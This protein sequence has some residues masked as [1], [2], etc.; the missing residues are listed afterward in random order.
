[1]VVHSCRTSQ[2]WLLRALISLNVSEV[3]SWEREAEV[4]YLHGK[5]DFSMAVT[6]GDGEKG[7]GAAVQI[8]RGLSGCWGA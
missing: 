6:A 7:K 4:W 1:M 2:R 8:R 3:D 5:N